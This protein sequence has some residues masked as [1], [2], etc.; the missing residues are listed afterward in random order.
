MHMMRSE[1]TLTVDKGP[2]TFYGDQGAFQTNHEVVT[3]VRGNNIQPVEFAGYQP[4]G[5]VVER[6]LQL[7]EKMAQKF[8]EFFLHAYANSEMLP[9]DKDFDCHSFVAFMM[10]T[11][12]EPGSTY[13][14]QFKPAPV[15][16]TPHDPNNL[17][18]YKSFGLVTWGDN[19]P[20][21]NAHSVISL[22]NGENMSVRGIGSPLV[23]ANNKEMMREF[24][25][26]TI[27]QTFSP[28]RV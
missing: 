28:P 13:H 18:P 9:G 1:L 16:M 25:A 6:T 11:M 14:P 23:I 15:E 24:G 8:G 12:E 4:V 21:E 26:K 22:P 10:D 5:E 17:E 27:H 20:I 3:S 19:G 7:P 2:H